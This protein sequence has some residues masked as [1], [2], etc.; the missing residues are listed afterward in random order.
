MSTH[1]EA[2][3]MLPDRSSQKA[4]P[5][6]NFRWVQQITAYLFLLP[7]LVI[8]GLFAW[9]PILR[10]VEMSFQN[11]QLSGEFTWV[12]LENYELMLRDP[13]F[14]AAWGNSFMFASWSIVLGYFVPIILAVLIREMRGVGGFF[15]IV[16]F[17]PT[18]V[19]VAVAVLI[20]RFIYDP[21]AGFLNALLLQLGSVRQTW[22]QDPALAKPAVVAMMTWGAFGT[23]ALIYLSTLQ[24]IPTELYEAAELDG[25]KP[26]QRIQNI[27]LPYLYPVMSA[28]FILQVIAVVQIFTEPFLMTNGGPGRETL[29][30]AMHIYNRAFIRFDLGYAAAWSVTMIVV[31]LVFSIIY[32]VIN[33]KL[34]VE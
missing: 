32:R 15:R 4:L 24:E 18:V 28:L 3:P 20:W 1:S 8:F 11:V 7:A 19:P 10:A 9:Y 22:L 33:H 27:T 5:K 26:M 13:A 21:D 25:A 31:L 34:T 29:T 2:K 30:P 16:Y 14:V 17:L 12:G 6:L 23:T